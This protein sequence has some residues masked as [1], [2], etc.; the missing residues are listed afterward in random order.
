MCTAFAAFVED[1][2]CFAL[3]LSLGVDSELQPLTPLFRKGTSF[4]I[5]LNELDGIL[6]PVN[7]CYIILR[8]DKSLNFI[9]YVPYRANKDDRAIFIKN[10][11]EC[12]RKLGEGRFTTSIICKEI[13]EVTD[14]RSWEE[15]DAKN[16][17]QNTVVGHTG[18][19]KAHHSPEYGK[20]CLIDAGHKKNKC[21]LCDRRMKNKMSPEA[22]EALAQ[23]HTPGLAVQI[24]LC[25]VLS[26]LQ[27]AANLL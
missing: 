1:G 19:H 5:A 2:S 13:G 25:P 22:L 4:Q 11:F 17:S 14:S 23:L 18:E 16:Q 15:R 26:F 3:P 20:E 24:V 9:T 21:R 27:S 12:V 8:R 7:S 10:R 6:T